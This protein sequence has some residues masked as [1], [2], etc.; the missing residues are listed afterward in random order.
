MSE[1]RADDFYAVLGPTTSLQALDS[2]FDAN[3]DMLLNLSRVV[4][5]PSTKI[6]K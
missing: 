2:F 6:E 1:Q 3:I 5:V 4:V